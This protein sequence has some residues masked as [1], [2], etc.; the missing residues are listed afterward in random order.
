ME[1]TARQVLERAKW[2]L[3]TYGISR[4]A[5]ES[6][7]DNPAIKKKDTVAALRIASLGNEESYEAAREAICRCAETSLLPKWNDESDDE[8]IITAF[9]EAI[10]QLA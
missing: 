5:F 9:D 1:P 8:T 6:P 3:E 10:H 2:S 4:G 7:T